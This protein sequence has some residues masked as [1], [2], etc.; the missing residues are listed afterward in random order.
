MAPDLPRTC[1]VT[2][3]Y[4]GDTYKVYAADW[5]LKG[6]S[7]H[8]CPYC[9]KLMI[10]KGSRAVRKK[11]NLKSIAEFKTHVEYCHGRAGEVLDR[12]NEI[13]LMSKGDVAYIKRMVKV[14]RL[15]YP[16]FH[17]YHM[18]DAY[19]IGWPVKGYMLVLDPKKHRCKETV[20]LDG[21]FSTQAFVIP[22]FRRQHHFKTLYNYVWDRVGGKIVVEGPFSRE[23]L[24]FINSLG[25]KKPKHA[26]RSVA[27]DYLFE[28]VRDGIP[29]AP[30]LPED[31]HE[32]DEYLL[33]LGAL[34]IN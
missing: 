7:F 15:H 31:P 5:V 8:Y 21:I 32:R 18:G 27:R 22:A 2:R 20:G 11:S 14:A 13:R 10:M 29:D 25:N 17:Q 12:E 30:P 4:N 34:D 24:A 6:L 28:K 16:G 26:G 9:F 1:E 3:G 19:T 23:A 33:G